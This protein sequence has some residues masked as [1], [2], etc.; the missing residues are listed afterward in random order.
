MVRLQCTEQAGATRHIGQCGHIAP[1]RFRAY[2]SLSGPSID[3]REASL[4]DV[5]DVEDM[6][7]Q[8]HVECGRYR[9]PIDISSSMSSRT[10]LKDGQ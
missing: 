2:A 7:V 5:I 10:F 3:A 8:P 4:G 6:I 9:S 1:S